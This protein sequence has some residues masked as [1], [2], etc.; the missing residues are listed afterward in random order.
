[1]NKMNMSEQ[2]C[3]KSTNG[4]KQQG[5]FDPIAY[6]RTGMSQD[7]GTDLTMQIEQDSFHGMRRNGEGWRWNVCGGW[8]RCHGCIHI[9][10]RTKGLLLLLPRGGRRCRGSDGC[11]SSGCRR[12]R[13]HGWRHSSRHWWLSLSLR[14]FLVVVVFLFLV[15]LN[16]MRF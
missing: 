1:M 2:E 3:S 13:G 8:W 12:G 4:H 5:S 11:S 10:R 14:S 9:G 6:T 16:G 15:V 7:K